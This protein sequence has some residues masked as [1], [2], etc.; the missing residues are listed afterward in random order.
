MGLIRRL[1]GKKKDLAVG[2]EQVKANIYE[3]LKEGKLPAQVLEDK[4]L[5]G[6]EL[7]SSKSYALSYV[8][9]IH[10]RMERNGKRY[11]T[12]YLQ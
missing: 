7:L 12:T 5:T 10:R 6:W 11:V 2:T 9:Y 8:N 1:L 4:R 3:C